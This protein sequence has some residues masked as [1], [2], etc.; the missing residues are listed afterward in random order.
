VLE[1]K[2]NAIG[3]K[4]KIGKATRRYNSLNGIAGVTSGQL[5]T[6]DYWVLNKFKS[7]K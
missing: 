3:R 2:S 7:F 6:Y 4:K 1:E 5:A